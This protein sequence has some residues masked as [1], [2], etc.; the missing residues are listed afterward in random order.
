M[1]KFVKKNFPVLLALVA[2]ALL[3]ATVSYAW[4]GLNNKLGASGT[5]LKLLN[6][7]IA[8]VT[9]NGEDFVLVDENGYTDDGNQHVPNT[10]S[11]PGDKARYR[12]ILKNTSNVEIKLTEIGLAKP[13]VC[14]PSATPSAVAKY[15]EVPKN[16]YYF[17]TQLKVS[18]VGIYKGTESAFSSGIG[19]GATAVYVRG[20]GNASTDTN[21]LSM[22]PK[23]IGGYLA[24][25]I[26]ANDISQGILAPAVELAQFTG[27]KL[28]LQANECVAVFV[29]VEFAESGT[30][31]DAYKDF[32]VEENHTELCKRSVYV[33]LDN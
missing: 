8:V 16:G 33:I 7:T 4:L 1:K 18:L 10:L 11:V 6:E 12:V 28:S 23:R 26:A 9:Q 27:T 5:N 30:A 3:C 22:T 32:G 24:S 17:G 31:Q 19:S 21:T 29:E 15:D 2:V 14:A 20:A 25:Y 13:N